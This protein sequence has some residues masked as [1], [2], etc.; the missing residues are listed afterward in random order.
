ME[1]EK[2]VSIIVTCFN[3]E[4]SLEQ[5]LDTLLANDFAD[6]EV[7]AVDDGSTDATAHILSRYAQKHACL[8]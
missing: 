3:M 1:F 4:H 6:M 7:I 2:T 5:A 8:V